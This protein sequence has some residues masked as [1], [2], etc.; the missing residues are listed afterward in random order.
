M[1]A[2]PDLDKIAW[3]TVLIVEDGWTDQQI[4]DYLEVSRRTVVRWKRRD[5]VQLAL[6]VA[7]HLRSRRMDRARRGFIPD[8]DELVGRRVSGPNSP[9]RFPE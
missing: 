2:Y 5:D 3:A 6:T 8:L 4:A 7:Y 9:V 1:P